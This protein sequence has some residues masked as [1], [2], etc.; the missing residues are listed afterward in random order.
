MRAVVE[1]KPEVEMAPD[2]CAEDGV[3]V[4][5]EGAKMTLG[6]LLMSRIARGRNGPRPCVKAGVRVPR[7]GAFIAFGAQIV[8][9]P[10]PE[11]ELA[12]ALGAEA[13]VRVPREP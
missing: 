11:V 3:R 8:R 6:A 12:L 9:V 5:R 4:P 13:G 10:K 2:S 1:W 7:E